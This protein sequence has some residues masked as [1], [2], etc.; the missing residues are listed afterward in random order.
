MPSDEE[1]KS[2][3]LNILPGTLRESLL[4]RA[5][6]PGPYTRFRDMVRSQ[7]AR[8]LLQQ[9]RLPLHRVEES[10]PAQ[11]ES[12]EELSFEAM[13]RDD[14]VAYVKRNRCNPRD[15][16]QPRGGGGS[17]VGAGTSVPRK[18]PIVAR[19]TRS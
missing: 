17:G 3:L 10:L 6:D 5:T 15:R 19:S 16:R 12:E 9:Q 2:D 18:C 8:S 13:S 11:D 1:K 7:A 14:L 4:W